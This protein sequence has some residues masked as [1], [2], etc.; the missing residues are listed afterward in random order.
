[1]DFL[2][3]IT[4]EKFV[5]NYRLR[6]QYFTAINKLEDGFVVRNKIGVNYNLSKLVDPS[7]SW[8]L[9]YDIERGLDQRFKFALKWRLSKDIDLN[10]FYALE[11]QMHKNVNDNTHIVGLLV[12]LNTGIKKKKK[13]KKS[14]EE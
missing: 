6:G 9:F 1:M 3:K 13:G 2:F 14:Q 12:T 5:F 7:L 4:P 11:R 8:E 10:S